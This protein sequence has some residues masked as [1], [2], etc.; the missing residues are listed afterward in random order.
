[1][2]DRNAEAAVL[3]A[4]GL[5]LAVLG[6]GQERR[7]EWT[8][9]P[10]AIAGRVHLTLE[11]S[12]PG[13]RS[14]QSFDVS[15]E[16]FRG[17]PADVF[18]RGGAAK[19]EY[20]HDAG[21]LLCQGRFSWSK[22]SGTF[23]FA[24]DPRFAVELQ[25][26]GYDAPDADQSFQM[27]L[28][29]A[30]LE[31]AR[32]VKDAGLYAS[33]QQLLQLRHHGIK[34]EYIREMI[35]LGYSKLTLEDYIRLRDHGVTTAFAADL[36]NAGYDLTAGRIVELR[37]HGV[38]S[39]FLNDL[40]RYGLTPSASELVQLRDHGVTPEYLKGLKNAGLENLEAGKITALRDHGVSSEFI[41]E[42][43]DLGY[44]FT[45]REIIE[46]RDHGVGR[47]YL[48][49]VRDSGIKNLSASQIVKLKDHGVD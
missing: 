29:D 23:T 30:T 16:R 10:S 5:V 47:E 6:I 32:G 41:Q 12:K 9:K 38:S 25:R 15:L 46:L 17:L 18:D 28:A 11:M 35:K 20:V 37:D 4:V 42:S 7:A 1:M 36:Q 45:P 43:V 40:Q 19:F 48:R 49:R 14:T 27:L 44:R 26:L 21:S 39:Q 34:L 24:P 22:G 3:V 8:L 13:Q 2:R 33:T 31:F